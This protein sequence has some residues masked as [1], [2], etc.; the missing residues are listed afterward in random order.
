MEDNAPAPVQVPPSVGGTGLA[1][2]SG[3]FTG[4]NLA[5][6]AYHGAPLALGVWVPV[7][8]LIAFVGV[9]LTVM[10][11]ARAR[12]GVV[13]TPASLRRQWLIVAAGFGVGVV[14]GVG[15]SVAGA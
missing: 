14:A 7:L 6:V 8:V 9:L 2:I 3:L 12:M 5:A 1:S 15:F 11:A 10:Q 4:L 13:A